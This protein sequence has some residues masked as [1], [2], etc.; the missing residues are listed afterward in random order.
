MDEIIKYL[1]EFF[2]NLGHPGLA[3]Y[4]PLIVFI[5][6]G[7]P[8]LYKGGRWLHN[9][10]QQGKLKKDLHPFYTPREVHEATRYYV[11]TK[12]QNVAPSTEYKQR[13]TVALVATE[14]LIPLFLN[15]AFKT[16]G[17][18]YRFYIVFADSGMGKTTF[19]LNLYLSY[20][21]RIFRKK[22]KIRLFPL[23]HPNTHAK[24]AQIPDSESYN[25]ILLLDAFDED[26][27]AVHNYKARLAELIRDVQDFRKVVI[28]CRTQFFPSE[29]DEPRET[30]ILKCGGQ[31]G[32]HAFHKFYISPFDDNDIELYLKKFTYTNCFC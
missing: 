7:I 16:D 1:Q 17:D 29:K 30:G 20:S 28:T 31:K 9:F 23:G 8:L 22:Y 18:D 24:I 19:L 14:K 11:P 27:K 5:V 32:F 21:R 6:A 25:T 26:S 4:I 13:Q 2:K 12:Y 3:S 15:K 10:W